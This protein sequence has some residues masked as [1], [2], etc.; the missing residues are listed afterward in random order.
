MSDDLNLAYTL[1]VMCVESLVQKF[2]GYEPQWFDIPDPKRQGVDKALKGVDE[3]RAQ[4]LKDA[5]L[6]VIHPRFGPSICSVYPCS[7]TSGLLH[8]KGRFAEISDR[9]S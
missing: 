5:V 7:L 9:S 8:G 3:E 6:D 4:A 1:L 2:D